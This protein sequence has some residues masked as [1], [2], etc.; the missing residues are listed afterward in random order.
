VDKT[1]RHFPGQIVL[2]VHTVK[3]SA[4]KIYY[5]V[6]LELGSNFAEEIDSY[7]LQMNRCLADGKIQTFGIAQDNSRVWATLLA[8]DEME[9]WEIVSALP[10]EGL[11][12]PIVTPLS[13]YNQS[14]DLQ[15][16][17]ICLN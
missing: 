10:I 4:M 17:V 6:E 11:F 1:P 5:L 13:T 15:F 7:T 9:A 12:D 16:P 14:L 8:D 2:Y 3:L